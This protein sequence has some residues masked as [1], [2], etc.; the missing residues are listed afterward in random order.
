[1]WIHD[2]DTTRIDV[3]DS[4]DDVDDVDYEDEDPPVWDRSH[5]FGD[6]DHMIYVF[7]CCHSLLLPLYLIFC[8]VSP[9]YI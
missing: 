2:G 6:T 4:L 8:F 5:V 9:S 7:L 3:V 1:M